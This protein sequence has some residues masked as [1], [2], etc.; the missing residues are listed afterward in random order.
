MIDP[1]ELELWKFYFVKMWKKCPTDRYEE[2]NIIYMQ[3]VRNCHPHMPEDFGSWWEVPNSKYC[4]HIILWDSE[5]VIYEPK[6]WD[7]FFNWYPGQK[8][9]ICSRYK[10]DKLLINLTKHTMPMTKLWQKLFDRFIKSKE[11]KILETSENANSKLEDFVGLLNPLLD[12][13]QDLRASLK[14]L[15]GSYEIQ[16]KEWITIN[17][18]ELNK[19][20][21]IMEDEKVTQLKIILK[22]LNKDLSK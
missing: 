6:N 13:I 22:S 9:T 7:I 10:E 11:T 14:K 15:D 4:Q 1:S 3:Y 20:I 18:N 17:L 21:K 8:W 5:D 19:T 16:N 2:W 12:L